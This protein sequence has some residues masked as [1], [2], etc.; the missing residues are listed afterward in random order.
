MAQQIDD[1][2]RPFSV[3]SVSD[4]GIEVTDDDLKKLAESFARG[5]EELQKKI[6]SLIL[7]LPKERP[8]S[9]I[10]LKRSPRFKNDFFTDKTKKGGIPITLAQAIMLREI[11]V[12][13]C[14]HH[15]S[16]DWKKAKLVYRDRDSELPYGLISEKVKFLKKPMILAF[17]Y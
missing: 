11:T 6:D 16:S 2:M 12:S 9:T 15:L 17:L 1:A 3:N 5:R 10:S 13:S 14:V 4:I 7:D 8:D